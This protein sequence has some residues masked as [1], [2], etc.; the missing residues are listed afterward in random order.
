MTYFLEKHWKS[1][2]YNPNDNSSICFALI[3]PCK[4]SHDDIRRFYRGLGPIKELWLNGCILDFYPERGRCSLSYPN[5]KTFEE[6]M[7]YANVDLKIAI[8]FENY[9]VEEGSDY[10]CKH[11]FIKTIDAIDN[12]IV[13]C[14]KLLM[15]KFNEHYAG[16][17]I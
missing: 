5:F 14:N 7:I 9:V 3:R 10:D 15:Q 8:D 1:S 13:S 2:S 11:H 16:N 17:L 6:F 12:T 4:H